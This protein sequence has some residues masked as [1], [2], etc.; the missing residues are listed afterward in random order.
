VPFTR[1][2]GHR[3]G[4]G[5]ESWKADGSHGSSK[6]EAVRLIGDGGVSFAQASQDPKARIR[7]AVQFGGE[8]GL[9]TIRRKHSWARVGCPGR[10]EVT[11]VRVLAP[12]R[13]EGRLIYR[14]GAAG[15]LPEVSPRHR[16]PT[17]A[18]YSYETKAGSSCSSRAARRAAPGSAAMLRSTG[19][20][21]R[22]MSRS[23][24]STAT[25]ALSLTAPRPTASRWRW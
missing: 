20:A 23:S 3:V 7:P 16:R 13:R 22:K 18:S 10:A 9:R 6:L 5:G 2:R 12:R 4:T 8:G 24:S 14:R 19:S 17:L 15:L 21:R 1:F 11:T 25:S